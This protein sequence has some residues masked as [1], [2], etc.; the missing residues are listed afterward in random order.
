MINGDK[1]ELSESQ[2][3]APAFPKT[4][5]LITHTKKKKANETFLQDLEEISIN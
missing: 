1:L 4:I 5:I 2:I 3:W